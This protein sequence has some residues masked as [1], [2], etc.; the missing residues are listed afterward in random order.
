MSGT[1]GPTL[2]QRKELMRISK[3]AL[4]L[5]VAIVT[6]LASSRPL[7]AAQAVPAIH[8]RI[9]EAITQGEIAGAV[10][11]VA[12][13]EKILHLDATGRSDL[14]SESPMSKDAIFWIAS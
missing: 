13:K 11:L 2:M 7:S 9:Q 12:D 14:A 3:L 8:D 10:T 4:S 1:A 5:L 6:I